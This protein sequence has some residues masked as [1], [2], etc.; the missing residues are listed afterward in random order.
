MPTT[1][2]QNAAVEVDAYGSRNDQVGGAWSEMVG[3][4][5]EHRRDIA[6]LFDEFKAAYVSDR[7]PNYATWQPLSSR[8]A[9]L[10]QQMA[11]I[12]AMVGGESTLAASTKAHEGPDVA[13]VSTEHSINVQA[14]NE[15]RQSTVRRIDTAND[16]PPSACSRIAPI[17]MGLAAGGD[18]SR[19]D[20]TAATRRGYVTTTN[21]MSTERPLSEMIEK[22]LRNQEMIARFVG[23]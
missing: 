20:M 2:P 10:E 23:R 8:F 7:D 6:K 5:F 13:L 19:V 14:T 9:A 15:I 4:F 11:R 1:Q 18:S 16:S 17:P 12:Q 3:A 21:G 22:M